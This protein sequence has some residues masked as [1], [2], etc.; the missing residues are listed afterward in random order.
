MAQTA[1]DRTTIPAW[2]GVLVLGACS[3]AGVAPPGPG[4]GERPPP[5]TLPPLPPGRDAGEPASPAMPGACVPEAQPARR[6]AVDLLLL[7]DVSSSMADLVAG[8]KQSKWDIVRAGLLGFLADPR[9][10]GVQV[11]LQFFPLGGSC[12]LAD[13][14]KLAVNFVDLPTVMPALTAALDGQ[15]NVRMNFGTPTGVALAAAHE[16]LRLRV[17]SLPDRRATLVLLTDDE[18]AACTPVAI[19]E[20]AAPVGEGQALNPSV[21]TYVIGVF[22]P[23][24]LARARAAVEK[25]ALAGGT[26]AFVLD[27]GLDLS[28][29]LTQTLDEI[30]TRAVPCEFAIPQPRQQV[31]DY[32]RFNLRL[33]TSAG[34]EPLR[35]VRAPESCPASGGGWY[36]DFDPT[37]S[38][39]KPGRVI[40]CPVSCRA[41]QADPAP[42][43]D[44]LFGCPTS[45]LP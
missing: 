45:T 13:F 5:F 11:G 8:G 28:V 27:A 32:R 34:V 7:V 38:G 31:L 21:A 36:F 43:V 9:S 12:A 39:G 44:V 14:E 22:S 3:A 40:T 33:T 37:T 17:R 10:R 24:E 29:R 20:V 16:V 25:L 41:F 15:T 23:A 6:L 19:D 1:A 26:R 42:R 2:L 35:Y 18:P 30:R 4:A